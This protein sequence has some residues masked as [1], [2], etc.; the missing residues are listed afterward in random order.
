MKQ[1]SKKK[2]DFEETTPLKLGKTKLLQ[3][4]LNPNKPAQT[5]HKLQRMRKH[6]VDSFV[7]HNTTSKKEQKVNS[8]YEEFKPKKLRFIGNRKDCE[9]KSEIA[10]LKSLRIKKRSTRLKLTDFQNQ[11][12]FHTT[13][14][15]EKEKEESN[16][17]I[18]IHSRYSVNEAHRKDIRFEMRSHR[19]GSASLDLGAGLEN[20]LLQKQ[21]NIHVTECEFPETGDKLEKKETF[22]DLMKFEDSSSEEESSQDGKIVSISMDRQ[23]DSKDSLTSDPEN[24]S[25]TIKKAIQEIPFEEGRKLR[26]LE[27]V[28]LMSK[29]FRFGPK[30]WKPSTQKREKRNRTFSG[31]SDLNKLFS[32]RKNHNRK[33]SSFVE[34]QVSYLIIIGNSQA[35][36]AQF[37]SKRLFQKDKEIVG[38]RQR[39]K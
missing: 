3:G 24:S 33:E 23:S 13:E 5:T 36:E 14:E 34:A 30:V 6:L 38:N 19:G 37:T 20:E 27:E 16:C 25:R 39:A 22:V 12:I 26:T 7:K 10:K 11:R 35:K 9:L 28:I 4:L 32:S 18:R 21:Y 29:G 2:A 15:P 8:F 31:A 1:K 17:P